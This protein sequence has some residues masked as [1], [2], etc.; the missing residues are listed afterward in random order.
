MK[1]VAA[2]AAAL[3]LPAAATAA[4]SDR[5]VPSV[6]ARTATIWAVGDGADGRPAAVEFGR[7]IARHRPTRFLYLGDVYERGTAAEFATNYHGA[8][9]RM[10]DVTAPTPGNHEWGNRREGYWPYWRAQK[11]VSRVPDYYTFRVAGWQILSLNSETEHGYGS[12]QLRWL[13]GR[14]ERRGTCRIAFAHKPRWTAGNRQETDDM[15]PIWQR[16]QGH[17]RLYISGHDHN[18]QRFRP[19]R[20]LIQIVAGAGGHGLYGVDE[21]YPRLVWSNDDDVAALRLRLRPGHARIAFIAN[22]GDVLHR[23]RVGCS[24]R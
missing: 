19:D 1:L 22:D 23:G 5:F 14:L 20:G 11:R 15:L 13:A 16:L 7:F 21:S 24:R 2:I 3:A 17:A 10:T 12:P 9:G 6:G 18:S 4:V 8:Y